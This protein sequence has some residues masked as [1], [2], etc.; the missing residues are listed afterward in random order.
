MTTIA[1]LQRNNFIKLPADLLNKWA[2]EDDYDLYAF[3]HNW[4]LCIGKQKT[5]GT[6]APIGFFV[7]AGISLP[8]ELV[9]LMGF[10]AGDE[11]CLTLKE[12]DILML[13]KNPTVA[14]ESSVVQ[15]LIWKRKLKREFRENAQNGTPPLAILNEENLYMF[16]TVE[17]WNPEFIAALSKKPE[18]LV[19]LWEKL[20][21]DD[22]LHDFF[23]ERV[24]VAM[25]NCRSEL[26]NAE[27]A[28]RETEQAETAQRGANI[29]RTS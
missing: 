14:M 6:I 13:R 1:T 9:T 4:D 29:F 3:F 22:E 23:G 12:N 18:L 19:S 28:Q 26:F 15:N 25:A 20:I 16:L 7:D 2:I 10:Q 24:R 17:E 11:I 8:P 27:L 21:S 5:G